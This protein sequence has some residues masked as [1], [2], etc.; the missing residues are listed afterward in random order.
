MVRWALIFSPGPTEIAIIA[1]KTADS[2]IVAQDLVGQCEHGLDPPAWLICDDE[3]FAKEVKEKVLHHI[4]RLPEAIKKTATVSWQNYGEIVICDTREEIVKVSVKYS[5][6]HLEV[7]T[8]DLNWWLANLN[9]YGSL[10]LGEETTVAF[11]D[12]CSGTNHVLPTKTAANYTGGLSVAKFIKV[13]TYQKMSKEASRDIA[14]TT[15]RI[16]RLEGMEAHARTGDV[17]LKKYFPGED[18]K[19]RH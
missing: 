5:A 7:Q 16:S 19:L 2:D 6:E 17:R 18:F 9:N 1:D 12:K 11:G 10:F 14:A 13:L 15:A 8:E 3:G 4:D